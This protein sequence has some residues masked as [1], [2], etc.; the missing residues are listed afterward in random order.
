M[1]SPSSALQL[2]AAGFSKMLEMPTST[3]CQIMKDFN[4][5]VLQCLNLKP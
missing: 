4:F 5:N 3:K 2:E 1:L